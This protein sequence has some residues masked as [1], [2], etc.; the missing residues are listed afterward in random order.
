MVDYILRAEKN[1][2]PLALCVYGLYLNCMIYLNNF[3][4][5]IFNRVAWQTP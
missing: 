3:M 2:P 4:K 5:I 1:D